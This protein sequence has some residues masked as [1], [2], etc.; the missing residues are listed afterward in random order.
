MTDDKPH[1]IRGVD[2]HRE[3]R[4][5]ATRAMHQAMLSGCH[6]KRMMRE[7]IAVREKREKVKR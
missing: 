1:K 4:K 2:A 7:V 3:M 5:D 6:H